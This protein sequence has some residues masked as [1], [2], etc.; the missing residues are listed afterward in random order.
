MKYGIYSIRDAAAHVFTAP[1]IDLTD[2]SAIR[3]FSQAV[4]N[5]DSMMNFCPTD[6]SLYRIGTL[7]VEA[8]T[9]EPVNPPEML[10]SADRLVKVVIENDD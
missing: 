9:I 7:H 2:D 6:F 8:G 1:T 10:V 5:P 3:S 4:N